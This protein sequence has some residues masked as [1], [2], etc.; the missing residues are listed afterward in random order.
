MINC[1]LLTGFCAAFL[2]GCIAALFVGDLLGIEWDEEY[3]G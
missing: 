3:W 2:A 1:L